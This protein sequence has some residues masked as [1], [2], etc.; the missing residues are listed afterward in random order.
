MPNLLSKGLLAAALLAAAILLPQNAFAES[1]YE[2]LFASIIY[3]GDKIG[4]VHYTIKYGPDGDIEEVR[5]RASVSVLGITLYR[6]TQDLEEIWQGQ[7]L[8]RLHGDSND[9]GSTYEALV[10]RTSSGF[11]STLNGKPVDIPGNAFPNSMWHYAI[12][13]QNLLF[14][15]IDLELR[16][17]SVA[18]R[19]ETIKFHGQNVQAERFDFTGEWKATLWFNRD[20]HL[21]KANVLTNDRD[22][23]ILLDSQ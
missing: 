6:F 1:T 3:K 14:N 23:E 15:T 11:D 4:Q 8:H 2:N 13:E 21:L 18:R 5:S 22:I 9:D 20:K 7:N 19:Q 17:V 10:T 12:T 16:K